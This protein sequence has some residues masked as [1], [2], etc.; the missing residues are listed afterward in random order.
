VPWEK[1]PQ[2][3]GMMYPSLM[4]RI[5]AVDVAQGRPGPVATVE[6]LM[7]EAEAAGTHTF[8]RKKPI[9]RPQRNPLEWRANLTQLKRAGRRRDRRYGR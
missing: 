6:R 8:P 7:E 1:A 4:F 2:I 5:N 3:D 9:V